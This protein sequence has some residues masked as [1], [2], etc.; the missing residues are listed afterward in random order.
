MTDL[1]KLYEQDYTAWA[2][3]NAALLKAGH[4][5]AVDVAHLIEELEDMGRSGQR[6]LES[7][8]SVLLTHLLKWQFQYRQ[9]AA[10]WQE[11]DGR[12][13]HNTIV[14]QRTQLQLLL[15]KQPG[16]K[17]LW[18]T[19]RDEAYADARVLAA[20]ET[21]LPIATFPETCP[22]T[23]EQILQQDDYLPPCES[24]IDE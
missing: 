16:M 12:S 5:D 19:A 13:W 7:Y 20:K 8:L 21:G 11:F 4:F 10:R 24:V 2:E 18:A 3:A 17:R 15:R 6:A 14:H 23:D 22:Y 9:L 1:T